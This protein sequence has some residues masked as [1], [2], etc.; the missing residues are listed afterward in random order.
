METIITGLNTT[1]L[2]LNGR[3]PF[4]IET[5]MAILIRLA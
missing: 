2:M 3:L 5:A 1:P 4:D